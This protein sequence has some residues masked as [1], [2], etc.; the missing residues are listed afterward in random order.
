MLY[1]LGTLSA[2]VAVLC[3]LVACTSDDAANGATPSSTATEAD[4]QPS[5][6]RAVEALWHWSR[7]GPSN[8]ARYNGNWDAD[9][10]YIVA[11]ADGRDLWP[12]VLDRRTGEPVVRITPSPGYGLG[13]VHLD[14]PW[15]VWDEVEDIGPDE[16]DA[17]GHVVNLR[18][19]RRYVVDGENGLPDPGVPS[20]WSVDDGVAAFT[21]NQPNRNCVVLF[22]LA[23]R[24]TRNAR[25]TER[26]AVG[27]S[28]AELTEH[29]L[30]VNEFS[31]RPKPRGCVR[32]YAARFT[33]RLAL[34]KF[35]QLPAR[36]ECNG[37]LGHVG[38]DFIAWEEQ[39]PAYQD[40]AR[41]FAQPQ[42]E[43]RIKIAHINADEVV[44]CGRWLYY[45]RDNPELPELRRWRP[46]RPVQ[47]IYQARKPWYV[48]SDP[49]CHDDR[50][51][52]AK[53]NLGQGLLRDHILEAYLPRVVR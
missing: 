22:D 35:R 34:S 6:S 44:A 32:V 43:R 46:G 13:P 47:I 51:V 31:P 24:Q 28:F 11:S 4:V 5:S 7:V 50:I 1:R 20:S 26:R 25:C 36:S 12:S 15:A 33:G 45:M 40:V 27:T 39:R 2:V 3:A 42:G 10:R 48:S 41:L 8:P 23:T 49:Q 14:T 21:V 30:A 29:G 19:G 53:A 52:F 18:T 9:A 38:P 17:R 37:F 16:Q